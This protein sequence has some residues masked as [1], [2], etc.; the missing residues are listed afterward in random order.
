MKLEDKNSVW[1]SRALS[2][3]KKVQNC[4]LYNRQKH[5]WSHFLFLSNVCG[6]K[7]LFDAQLCF[8]LTSHLLF[9]GNIGSI[10]TQN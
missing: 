8:V 7:N 3:I 9:P 6:E 5:I 4:K 10:S 2:Q 1:I